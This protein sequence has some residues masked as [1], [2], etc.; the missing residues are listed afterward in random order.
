M[1][2]VSPATIKRVKVLMAKFIVNGVS[3]PILSLAASAS[4]ASTMSHTCMEEY[5]ASKTAARAHASYKTKK[6]IW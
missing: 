3:T 6:A 1:R 2:T 5:T 4:L